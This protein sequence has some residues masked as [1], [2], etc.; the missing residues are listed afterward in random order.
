M[1]SASLRASLLA[2][3]NSVPPRNPLPLRGEE[4]ASTLKIPI[5]FR[6]KKRYN[7]SRTTKKAGRERCYQHPPARMQ[8]KWPLPHSRY[9]CARFHYTPSHAFYQEGK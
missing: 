7:V 4:Y 9:N 8:E 3:G 1:G 2:G 6:R 5:A